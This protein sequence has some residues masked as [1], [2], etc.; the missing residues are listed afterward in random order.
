MMKSKTDWH[1]IHRNLDSDTINTF[2]VGYSAKPGP[3]D[4]IL[5]SLVLLK[6]H[7]S[8]VCGF[9][10]MILITWKQ[11]WNVAWIGFIFS[12]LFSFRQFVCSI[13]CISHCS[14]ISVFAYL[15]FFVYLTVHLNWLN[16]L[17]IDFFQTVR[18]SRCLSI[19]A[20]VYLSNVNPTVC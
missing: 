3:A 20:I 4:N 12:P 6:M 5:P 9:A 17:S 8:H 14:S 13:I 2:L 16:F 10:F 19:P 18:L 7:N 15:T 11:F 1:T